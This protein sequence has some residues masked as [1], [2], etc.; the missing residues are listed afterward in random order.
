MTDRLKLAPI[1]MLILA[2]C[3]DIS[4]GQDSTC[5]NFCECKTFEGNQQVATCIFSTVSADQ[6]FT[7]INSGLTSWLQVLCLETATTSQFAPGA[8]SHLTNLRR[9]D[10]IGCQ[11]GS[12]TGQT[13]SGLPPSVTNLTI[14][15]SKGLSFSDGWLDGF[16]TIR[17]LDLS[18]NDLA[19]IPPGSLCGSL[20]SV[21]LSL[22]A[23]E[24]FG[25]LGVT[26]ALGDSD[27][28]VCQPNLE[29]I[30]ISDN[31]FEEITVSLVDIMPRLRQFN[32]YSN[33]L[34]TLEANMFQGM[35]NL[36]LIDLTWNDLEQT[37]PGIF[38]NLGSLNT[39]KLR[40]NFI[41]NV[42]A[43]IFEGSP[44]IRHLDLASNRLS[45]SQPDQLRFLRDLNNLEYLDL[46]AND[47]KLMPPDLLMNKPN[48]NTL[49]LLY[50]NI[51]SFPGET[52]RHTPNLESLNL[53]G[54]KLGEITENVFKG[55]S[56][57]KTLILAANALSAIHERAF[58]H[59]PNLEMLYIY[60]NI[61]P[62]MPLALKD[63]DK[64]DTLYANNNKFPEIDASI[65]NDMDSLKTAFLD[66][67]LLTTIPNNAFGS[68]SQ[69][70]TL[71]M[72]YNR[73]SSFGLAAFQGMSVL[74]RLWLNANRL[75]NMQ[76]NFQNTLLSELDLSFNTIQRVEYQNFPSQMKLLNLSNNA[77][78]YVSASA[79]TY[80]EH[81]EIVDLTKNK[82]SM[83]SP[84][85]INTN[86]NPAP[87]FIL[88][89]NPDHTCTCSSL[90]TAA[91]LVCSQGYI[92]SNGVKN[93]FSDYIQRKDTVCDYE[94]Y[95]DI[96]ACSCCQDSACSC[97]FT[98]PAGCTC[99][100]NYDT[101]SHTITCQGPTLNQIPPG[102][103]QSS[104]AL[105]LRGSQLGTI[106]K[107]TLLSF[108]NLR[109]LDIGSSGVTEIMNN[110]FMN[111]VALEELLL[112]GN[113]I[114][115]IKTGTFIGLRALKKLDL[116][117]NAITTIEPN[118]FNDLVSLEEL[119]L[120]DNDLVSIDLDL[121][122]VGRSLVLHL[123]NN[124]WLCDCEFGAE[125]KR[126]MEK[127]A[128]Q[129]ANGQLLCGLISTN[130]TL[131][132]PG[133]AITE[134]DFSSCPTQGNEAVGDQK[135]GI[136]SA[137]TD[138]KMYIIIGVVVPVLLILVGVAIFFVVRYRRKNRAPKKSGI[139]EKHMGRTWKRS[140]RGF[141]QYAESV[142]HEPRV[143]ENKV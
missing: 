74:K 15:A 122:S 128:D 1:L 31:Y 35:P 130:E 95:C 38:K 57:L 48:L 6:T 100:R 28:T 70:E 20:I 59:T 96:N 25:S 87:K 103:P 86:S 58:L 79:F 51:E 73:I 69:I 11:L 121:L 67:N 82:L 91:P 42:E 142:M 83:F 111:L 30:D 119:Y 50:S 23:F 5:P 81:L 19:E 41:Y 9:L 21:N 39:L 52:F 141:S 54:N 101:S 32:A 92:I 117:G 134:V 76:I 53:G 116:Q 65:L 127:S 104:T 44:K 107:N 84:A 24:S 49:R 102:L 47:F 75:T 99:A 10:I 46:S 36:E 114:K 108:S 72:S 94:T 106:G 89:Q 129:I 16:P 77:I 137:W 8:F 88:L 66:G 29:V 14:S 61:L 132:S 3:L 112:G 26:C 105:S 98:C 125:F 97:R 138:S 118:S 80:L 124:N 43:D 37:I 68:N 131:G 18:N 56:N 33:L 45:G 78:N 2:L 64:L 4:Q 13:I 90:A 71:D 93:S 133:E 139:F 126:W 123:H 22:N 62:R 110:A 27:C 12:V 34:Y 113:S 85:M 136:E 140:V 115:V 143:A 40:G 17:N 7:S 63:L 55:L 109:K 120:N 135:S 60:N